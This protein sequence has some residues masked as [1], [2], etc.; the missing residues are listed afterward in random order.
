MYIISPQENQSSEGRTFP[1]RLQSIFGRYRV[2]KIVQEQLG[3][4]GI[5][6]KFVVK[7]GPLKKGKL[8]FTVMSYMNCVPVEEPVDV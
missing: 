5:D 7:H 1:G 8:Q 6:R 3:L 2:G 4:D